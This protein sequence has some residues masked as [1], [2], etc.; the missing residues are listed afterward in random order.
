MS[1]YNA[2][3]PEARDFGYTGDMGW[4]DTPD[5]HRWKIAQSRW[6]IGFEEREIAEHERKIREMEVV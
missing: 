3:F 6:L 1:A 4:R 5:W 2:P